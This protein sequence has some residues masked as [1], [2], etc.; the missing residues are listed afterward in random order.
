MYQPSG[1][2][3][4]CVS[5]LSKK[6]QPCKKWGTNGAERLSKVSLDD[7]SQTQVKESKIN[8]SR[9]TVS[10]GNTHMF[11]GTAVCISGKFE[12]SLTQDLLE[13]VENIISIHQCAFRLA[14][15]NM[16]SA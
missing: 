14:G 5:W 8:L 2:L 12:I 15:S 1:A 6:L 3:K 16:T 11:R 13:R 7:P 10:W 4:Q 9:W